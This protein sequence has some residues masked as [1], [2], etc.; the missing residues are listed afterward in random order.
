MQQPNLE[1]KIF[2]MYRDNYTWC[3]GSHL[4]L[5]T[6]SPPLKGV[7]GGGVP[8]E[9]L[10]EKAQEAQKAGYTPIMITEKYGSNGK[11]PLHPED[12]KHIRSALGLE[13]PVINP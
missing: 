5:Y 12:E 11:Y 2:L 7:E 13:K 8:V 3:V 10:I 4:I 9:F 6:T 1:R